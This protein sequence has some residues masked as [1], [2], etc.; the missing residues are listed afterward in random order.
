VATI[1]EGVESTEG[2]KTAIPKAAYYALAVLTLA[3][4]FNYLDRQVVSILAQSIKHDLMLD[5]AQ[6]GFLLGT[7][8]A[9]FYSVVGIAMGRIA[10]G[11][12]RKKVMA[13]GLTVWSAMTALG[14]GATS[15]AM[16][17]LARVGVG[18]GEAVANPCSHSLVAELFPQK[19]RAVAMSILMSGVFLGGAFAMFIGGLFLT[20]WPYA[21]TAVPIVGACALAPWKAALFGVS[22]PGL[23]LALMLLAIQE[24]PTSGHDARSTTALVLRE[25]ATALPPFTVLTLARIGGQRALTTNLLV[26]AV[27]AAI[28]TVLA[29]LTHDIAQWAA[30]GLGGYAVITWGHIQKFRD[31]PLYLLT[32]GDPTFA[33]ATAACALIA[34]VGGTANVWAAPYAMRTY[35]AI[36]AHEIGL[37]LGLTSISGSL[38]GVLLGGQ[39]AD[40][41]KQRDK[42]APMWICA[43]ALIGTVPCVVSMLMVRDFH[44]FLMAL[45][46]LGIFSGMWSPGGAAMV[47]DLVLPR[48]R[49]SS[50]A[51]YSLVAIVVSS[52]TGPYWA[53]KVSAVT[54]SLTLGLLSVMP[55]APFAL[56]SL[57]LAAR[58]LPFETPEAR[59]ARA[60]AAG[61]PMETLA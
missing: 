43:I 36:P 31:R 59:R 20:K 5:D 18:V 51:C 55:L 27:I 3:N 40:R 47:Q 6:L 23:P 57:W 24:P 16:L 21:C 50:S 58:R 25:I 15:F 44:A 41:W 14:G 2:R 29:V 56:L 39:A 38:L 19:N 49:G 54:G 11:L 32:F 46:L 1:A 26:A 9:V 8:F 28:S 4:V 52:G 53:G 35:T 60:A 61:E 42:R 45:F 33:F 30:F 48:M 37:T 22:I 34:C 7:A 13:F 12:P 10:D 17:G